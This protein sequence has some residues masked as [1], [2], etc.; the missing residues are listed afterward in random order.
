MSPTLM[1]QIEV[2]VEKAHQS[3]NDLT[4]EHKTNIQN[5]HMQKE[6]MHR[7]I[8]QAKDEEGKMLAG[9]SSQRRVG[10]VLIL[11]QSSRR[12]VGRRTSCRP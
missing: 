4:T 8:Q 12:S 10:Q 3:V 5:M 7:K 1:R 11:M 9:P 6:E 2:Y